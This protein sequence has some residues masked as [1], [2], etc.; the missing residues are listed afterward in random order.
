M[1][2][3]CGSC[4]PQRGKDVLYDGLKILVLIK[5]HCLPDSSFKVAE[6]FMC[7]ALDLQPMLDR[8]T[9]CDRRFA[10]SCVLPRQTRFLMTI[11]SC[12]WC[13]SLRPCVTLCSE[14]GLR[15]WRLPL[16]LG[17]KTAI[18]FLN[19]KARHG[20]YVLFGCLLPPSKRFFNQ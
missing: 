13:C 17:G 8:W 2:R 19:P 18:W 12:Y 5:M 11:W 4:G 15:T 1:R 3:L 10:K 9:S 16:W 20:A 14:C 6:V 7:R